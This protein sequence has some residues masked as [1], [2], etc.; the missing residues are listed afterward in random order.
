MILYIY[1]L[2]LLLFLLGGAGE[3][4]GRFSATRT[5]GNDGGS[6]CWVRTLFLFLHRSPSLFETIINYVFSKLVAFSTI[7]PPPI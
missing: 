1:H 2:L 3:H 7:T 6:F 5:F 4:W